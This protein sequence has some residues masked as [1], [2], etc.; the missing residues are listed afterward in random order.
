MSASPGIEPDRRA[1]RP[2]SGTLDCPVG[3]ADTNATLE[4]R[5]VEKRNG[6]VDAFRPDPCRAV[7]LRHVRSAIT[8]GTVVDGTGAD[9]HRRHRNHR[10][11]H[12]RRRY[13]S[14][15]A[16]EIIDARV[17]CHPRLRR[18]ALHYD[19]QATWT[20]CSSR[21]PCRRHHTRRA[22]VASGS[23][24][25][26]GK[27]VAHPA[28]G[29]SETFRNCPLRRHRFHVG[30]VPRYLD[31][32]DERRWSVDVGAQVRGAVR[33]YVMGERARERAPTPTTSNRWP[34]SCD[35]RSRRAPLVCRPRTIAHTAMDGEPV[36]GTLAAEDLFAMGRALGD[37]GGGVRTPTGRYR[38]ARPR[39]TDEGG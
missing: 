25:K 5:P 9:R 10:R 37:G 18:R 8:N 17:C 16:N 39:G 38:R 27:G 29:G 30:V 12:R 13:R 14:G 22:T 7:P 3:A 15:E 6:I 21:V 32:L 4:R 1:R 19:G 33:A 2:P 36:P 34:R 28:D 31:A 20:S 24:V 11:P 26:P 23:L 35:R